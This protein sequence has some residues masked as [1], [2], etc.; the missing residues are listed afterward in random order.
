ML[1]DV[2]KAGSVRD[3]TQMPTRALGTTAPPATMI[4][5]SRPAP[6]FSSSLWS[7]PPDVDMLQVHAYRDNCVTR[8][9][10]GMS[11][12]FQVHK[13]AAA[14]RRETTGRK[15]QPAIAG[16][17]PLAVVRQA[18]EATGMGRVRILDA[19]TVSILSRGRHAGT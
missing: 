13:H 9:S 12:S 6:C 16:Q 8:W 5:Y 14:R 3:L 4:R 19:R 17:V 15:A 10:K 7:F 18:G 1:T 11:D 2:G